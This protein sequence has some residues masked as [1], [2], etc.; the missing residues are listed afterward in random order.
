MKNN[1]KIYIS[2]GVILSVITLIAIFAFRQEAQTQDD[3]AIIQ[4]GRQITDKERAFG[5]AFVREGF[6]NRKRLTQLR[7]TG[8]TDVIYPAEGFI[9]GF[10]NQPKL[11]IEAI[12]GK[13]ICESDA[14]VIGKALRK[15]THLTEDETFVYS[16]YDVVVGEI[17]KNNFSS[18]IQPNNVIQ[19]ARPG[20]NVRIEGR[21]VRFTVETFAPLQNG[22][23]YLLFLKFVPEV[24]S[25][26]SFYNGRD[27][28]LEGKQ[29]QRSKISVSKNSM[30]K[31]EDTNSLLNL[32]RSVTASA[33]CKQN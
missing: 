9:G 24:N 15:T 31:Y 27:Y 1:R 3:V 4:R 8:D 2:I 12:W 13:R 25:Y 14:V 23:D 5:R 30:N 26:K 10:P 16:E 18:T 17:I 28:L 33:K 32:V 21:L 22:K 20:G 11:S 6:G 19:I 29:A 7:G